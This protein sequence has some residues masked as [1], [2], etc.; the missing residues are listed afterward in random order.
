MNKILA[1]VKRQCAIVYIEDFI[2]F[3]KSPEEHVTHI[4][5]VL[6]VLMASGM[7]LKFKKCRFFFKEI[8]YLGHVISQAG[9]KLR[10]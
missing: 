3:S 5:G 9:F 10:E 6:R 1:F 4:D 8:D 7:T 2:V